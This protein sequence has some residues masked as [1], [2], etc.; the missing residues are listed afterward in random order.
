MAMTDERL[1]Q[2]VAK[3][4]GIPQ[5][6]EITEL[7]DE[8]E[9]LKALQ[10]PRRV[11]SVLYSN[12]FTPPLFLSAELGD[13]IIDSQDKL[14][15]MAL[16]WRGVGIELRDRDRSLIGDRVQAVGD[17]LTQVVTLLN[18]LSEAIERHRD[19]DN[20]S[21]PSCPDGNHD[22]QPGPRVPARYG[23]F[24]SDVCARCGWYRTTSHGTGYWR[25]G[26]VPTDKDYDDD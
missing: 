10:E 15:D 22:P 13:I 14:R 12:S 1:R 21:G 2:I 23:T 24:S 8:I 20:G 4:R 9:R 18:D 6:H 19:I 16:S 7:V 11:D 26:P 3:E 25:P 5:A 17:A